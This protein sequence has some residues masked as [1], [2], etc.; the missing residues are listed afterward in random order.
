MANTA[1]IKA[2]ITAEDKASRVLDDF[3]G[4]VSHIARDAA[5]AVAAA[6][7]AVITFGISS[8]KAFSESQDLIS[9]T[10]AVLKSTGGIAGVT[11]KEVTD[12]AVAWQKQTKFSD[13]AIRGAE[14]LLLTF[15]AIGKDK[16]PQATE[17][18]L[19][20][21][22][23]LGQD[24]KSSSIQLGKALQ[25]PV[26]GITALR[27]VGVNFS[28]KQKDVV[29]ALV[30]T[31]RAG[32][33]QALILKELQVEFGGSA[34]AAGDT[35]S[36]QLA[37][38]K[39]NFNDVQESIGKTI[40]VGL[41]P[42]SKRLADF[43]ASDKF[44]KWLT[45]L[46]DWLNI[47]LPKAMDWLINTGWPALK[48]LFDETWPIIKQVW[49]M[50]TGLIGYLLDHKWI[51]EAIVGLFVAIKIAMYLNGAYN[52]FKGVI[53]ATTAVYKGFQA[54]VA[55]PLIMPAIVVTAALASLAL[56]YDAIQ[57]IKGAWDAV[58]NAQQ[59]TNSL[60]SDSQ[61]IALQKQAA[62]ARAAGDTKKVT[63]ISNA[64]AALSGGRAGGGEVY[65][66]SAYTVG[67]KGPEVFMPSE[68]G[69]IIPANQMGGGSTINVSFNGVFTGN[70]QD[71]RKLAIDVFKAYDDAK[72]MGT[73]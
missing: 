43:V 40:V 27:R 28:E 51:L 25:D 14:N 6:G 64:I 48:R 35:F 37:K 67:E 46:T 9:Q 73:V 32:E 54:I 42:L 4:K 13:E 22:A 17:A 63:Q 69:K 60:G 45:Q 50:F 5:V 59:A 1:N 36:G 39:N 21:S 49:D 19:N 18:V 31:G 7:A 44:Q 62:I 55:S 3:G 34:K 52:A 23:A 11:A 2:V 58:N 15:T 10:N 20:M 70:Q 30:E 66:G 71:F 24:L 38:L 47:N 29:K 56:V 57:K 33:A 68:R 72:G 41:T 12:L 61:V 65:P 16:F 8:V 26:L 53:E